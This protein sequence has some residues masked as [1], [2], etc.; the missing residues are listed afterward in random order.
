MTNLYPTKIYIC[1]SELH[2]D[3]DKIEKP[4]MFILVSSVMTW[5]RSKPLDQ[6]SPNVESKSLSYSKHH[7]YIIIHVQI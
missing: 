4:K 6:A 5:A 3:L 1:F 2:S 7:E